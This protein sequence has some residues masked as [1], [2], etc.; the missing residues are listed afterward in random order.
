MN[1]LILIACALLVLPAKAQDSTVVPPDLSAL[2]ERGVA[3]EIRSKTTRRNPETGRS[4]IGLIEAYTRGVIADAGD[5]LVLFLPEEE[6]PAWI[7]PN[8]VA[9]LE[10]ADTLIDLLEAEGRDVTVLR[11]LNDKWFP[12]LSES[13]DAAVLKAWE[14]E[15]VARGVPVILSMFRFEVTEAGDVLPS[16]GLKNISN[17]TVESVTIELLGFNEYGDVVRDRSTDMATHYATL[18]GTIRPGDT[19]LYSYTDMPLWNNRSTACIEIRRI[20][21]TFQDGTAATVDYQLKEAR[22]SPDLYPIMG[23][24]SRAGSGP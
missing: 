23:E 12:R 8:T 9:L 21:A 7:R 18:G 20:V 16:F 22:M 5:N 15:L 6:D 24:C 13:E 14:E 1:R 17:R 2:R 3:A 10:P 4:T 19:A 11:E